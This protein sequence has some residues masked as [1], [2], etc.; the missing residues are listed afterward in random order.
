MFLTEEYDE[1]DDVTLLDEED[2][3]EDRDHEE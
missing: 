2:D 3:G 1:M